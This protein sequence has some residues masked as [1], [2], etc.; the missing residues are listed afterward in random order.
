MSREEA[1]LFFLGAALGVGVASAIWMVVW[2]NADMLWREEAIAHGAAQYDPKTA[3]F[4]WIEPN[5]E[6]R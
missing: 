4:Q 3:E 6:E 5:G 1:G 2:G